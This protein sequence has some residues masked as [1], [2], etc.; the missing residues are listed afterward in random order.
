MNKAELLLDLESKMVKIIG[1]V[2]DGRNTNGGDR[3]YEFNVLAE[4]SHNVCQE[5]IIPIRVLNEG[6][7]NEQAFYV[8]EPPVNREVVI[9]IELAK[10]QAAGTITANDLSHLDVKFADININEQRVFVT[11]LNGATV[12][13][14]GK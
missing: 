6:S 7:E 4:T 14:P 8:A 11:I 2:G 5:R 10:L 9:A 3:E 12:V 1:Q 13:L